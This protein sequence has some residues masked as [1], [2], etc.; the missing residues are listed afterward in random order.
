MSDNDI[1][2]NN[3]TPSATTQD[4]APP[5]PAP[6]NG[7]NPAAR[8]ATVRDAL[9][10]LEQQHERGANGDDLRF[11]L[12]QETRNA[13]KKKVHVAPPIGYQDNWTSGCALKEQEARRP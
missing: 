7:E 2:K 1:A 10:L 13:F 3:E 4:T 6:Q 11:R 5:A 8:P 9:E 12:A